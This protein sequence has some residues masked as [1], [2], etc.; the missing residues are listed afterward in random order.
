VLAALMLALP[1]AAAAHHHPDGIGA[2]GTCTL[3]RTPVD[4]QPALI[5]TPTLIEPD[6]VIS[7]APSLVASPPLQCADR[8]IRSVRGPPAISR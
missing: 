5:A 3:C 8:P 2:D 1:V 4:P 7:A 6:D